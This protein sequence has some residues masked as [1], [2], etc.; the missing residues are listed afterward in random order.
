MAKPS[1]F[2]RLTAG[3]AARPLVPP[4]V[5][6]RETPAPGLR[7][8]VDVYRAARP[9]PARQGLPPR[10]P[11]PPPLEPAM[12]RTSAA[13][14]AA[15]SRIDGLPGRPAPPRGPPADAESIPFATRGPGST[16]EPARP[17]RPPPQ[18]KNPVII[19]AEPAPP[20]PR[21]LPASWPDGPNFAPSG[22]QAKLWIGA[23]EVRITPP[24]AKVPAKPAT[25]PAQ[26]TASR[27]GPSQRMSPERMARPFRAYG[28]GQ[29]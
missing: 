20:P 3:P 1:Y 6:F 27:S 4:R 11:E 23:L 22:S 12:A 2:N 18:V 28:L 17:E 21:P 7:E 14:S 29:S 8:Q 5:L 25:P 24:A 15:P 10:A 26:A 16:R 19:V 13:P 9:A